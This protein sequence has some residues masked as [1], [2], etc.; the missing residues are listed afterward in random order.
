[1]KLN[2]NKPVL[3]RNS[4]GY[5]YLN[6][7]RTGEQTQCHCNK[8]PTHVSNSEIEMEKRK[9]KKGQWSSEKIMMAARWG[10]EVGGNVLHSY[11]HNGA[12]CS[13]WDEVCWVQID[14]WV[15]K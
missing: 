13:V 3:N 4:Q 15:V 2:G 12:V 1:M 7:S 9:S 11:K 8:N 10:L 14:S 5:K 6:S